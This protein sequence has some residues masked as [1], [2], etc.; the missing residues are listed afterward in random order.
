MLVSLKCVSAKSGTCTLLAPGL[1]LAVRG[2]QVAAVCLMLKDALKPYLSKGVN[3]GRVLFFFFSFSFHATRTETDN[4][5]CH[6]HKYTHAIKIHLCAFMSVRVCSVVGTR[7]SSRGM[8]CR[9]ASSDLHEFRFHC[10]SSQNE[11][12]ITKIK[13]NYNLKVF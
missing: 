4:L 6:G 10:Y 5:I 13:T 8:I 11:S 12:N 1:M 7:S 3:A 9:D 2:N